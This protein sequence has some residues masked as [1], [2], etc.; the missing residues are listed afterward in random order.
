VQLKWFGRTSLSER[1]KAGLHL[2]RRLSG[3]RAISTI[4]PICSLKNRIL[5][6][7]ARASTIVPN[8]NSALSEN[9]GLSGL[10]GGKSVRGS[11]ASSNRGPSCRSKIACT[12]ISTE[13]ELRRN[14]LRG[15]GKQ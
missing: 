14:T 9:V 8:Y 5:C 7:R 2:T 1:K 10:T 3:F 4:S 15:R 13:F 11:A 6:G 12:G